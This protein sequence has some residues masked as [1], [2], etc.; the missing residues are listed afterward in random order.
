VRRVT[1]REDEPLP[2]P[3]CEMHL[4]H[5]D[6]ALKVVPHPFAG[7]CLVARYDLPP[8]YKIAFWGNR[9]PC[10]N[11]SEEDRAISY[12]PPD[13]HTGKNKDAD[14]TIRTNYNG[15]LNPGGTGDLIQFAACPGPGE[16]QNMRSTFQYW[17]VRNGKIG[18]LEFVTLDSIPKNTQLCHW[19]GPGWWSAR[20]VKRKDV[21]T[22]R[23]PV[24]KRLK[25]RKV[26]G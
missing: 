14:G 3:Y 13:R 15:V 26:H 11:C 5:G 7:K 23:Y 1:P 25:Q 9:G 22:K 21:G 6:G 17:G 4:K 8:K 18:G 10:K 24:P 16:R 12:Y 19:Y 2:I 20:G